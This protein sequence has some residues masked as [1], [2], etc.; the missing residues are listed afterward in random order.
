MGPSEKGLEGREH[1]RE[2]AAPAAEHDSGPD[3]GHAHAERLGLPRGL[4]PRDAGRREEV[5]SGRSIFVERFLPS[6]AVN[7]DG[8]G[9][10]ENGRLQDR[11][12]DRRAELLGGLEAA[13]HDPGLR[14]L[15]PALRDAF[16]REIHDSTRAVDPRLPCGA[17]RPRHDPDLRVNEISRPRSVAREQDDVMTFREQ[18][19]PELRTDEPG[20]ARHDDAHPL[21]SSLHRTE[22]PP[23]YSPEVMKARSPA[24]AAL[25]ISLLPGSGPRGDPGAGR[26]RWTRATSSGAS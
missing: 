15:R 21:S 4:L 1:L 8:R 12:L 2:R 14:G 25:A 6:R 10:H 24:C 18:A 23:P 13:R 16:A 17:S 22:I 11:F 7:A 5:A 26:S 19:L 9:I 20:P 3:Q